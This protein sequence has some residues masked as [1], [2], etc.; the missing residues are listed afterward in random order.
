[1]LV[2]HSNLSAIPGFQAS[3][4][5][6]REL[7]AELSHGANSVPNLDRKLGAVF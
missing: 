1:M 3:N 5:G 4:P 2:S 6:L 7:R